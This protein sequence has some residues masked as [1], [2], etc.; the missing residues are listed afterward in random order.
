MNR[1][2]CAKPNTPEMSMM[3]RVHLGGRFLVG[4]DNGKEIFSG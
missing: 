3:E 4:A 1:S 2:T